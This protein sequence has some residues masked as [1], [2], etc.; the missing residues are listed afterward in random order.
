VFRA[1]VPGA[2]DSD[3]DVKLTQN[4][5][6]ISGKRESEKTEKSDAFYATEELRQL[7][8]CSSNPSQTPPMSNAMH[9]HR[10]VIVV[11]I[12][13]T[14]ASERALD[15]AFALARTKHGVQLHVVNVRSAFGEQLTSNESPAT[16]PPWRLWATELREY[17]ARK[18]AASQ[19]TAGVTPFQHVYTHQRMNDAAHEI[20]QL[21]ADVEADLVVVGTH[22]WHGSSRLMLGSVAD[23]VTRLAPCPV[24]VVRRK[25]VPLPMRAIQPA[26][27]ACLASRAAS[28]GSELWCEQHREQHGSDDVIHS[29]DR[30][31]R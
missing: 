29:N 30:T 22:D 4:R 15:E 8:P 5:L 3:L 7:H 26:C 16:L 31:A 19:A 23:A 17:V 12:D 21:A 1:D 2:E 14:A 6:S 24:L 28:K 27:A 13:Y 20:A 18:V 10:Y 9:N 25:S 11:G